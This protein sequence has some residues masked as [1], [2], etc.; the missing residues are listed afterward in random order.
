MVDFFQYKNIQIFT[1]EYDGL[2]IIN[3]PDNKIFSL[4]QLE[5]VIL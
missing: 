2:K 3:K 1:L 5:K 4:E